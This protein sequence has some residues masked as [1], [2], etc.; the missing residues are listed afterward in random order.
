MNRI[1]RIYRF[2]LKAVFAI[3]S[4]IV[5]CII[6]YGIWIEPYRIEVRHIKVQNTGLNKVL[7]NK[8]A[9]H[10][11]DLHILHI[12]RRERNVL[13]LIDELK[14]DMIFLTGDYVGWDKGYG[15]ALQFL[16]ALRA[17]IGIWAVMGD[18]DYSNSR[19]S[20]LFCHVPGSGQFA[21]R[22]KIHFL[23]N[24]SENLD[25]ASG[26]VVIAGIEEDEAI[27]SDENEIWL[28]FM[29]SNFPAIILSHN[30]LL[31]SRLD[32]HRNILMLAGDTHGGQ[33]PLPSWMWKFLG[34]EKTAKYGQ[35]YFQPFFW[36]R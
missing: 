15:A 17:N 13:K 6:G 10:V 31:F 29:K 24:S 36:I 14:P 21:R 9:L 1:F 20:C 18:Y 5:F 34:Y 26:S 35:G 33:I 16:S 4:I 2:Q 27:F 7:K 22:N 25:F 30:P 19:K 12:G 11:S 32:K 8:T 28:P 3:L 23:R